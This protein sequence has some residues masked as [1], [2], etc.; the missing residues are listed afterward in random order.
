[1]LAQAL[2]ASPDYRLAAAFTEK[3]GSFRTTCYIWVRS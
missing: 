2:E 1:V 3:S